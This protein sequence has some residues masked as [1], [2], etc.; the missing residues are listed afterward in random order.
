MG[1]SALLAS[2][3]V[4]SL[5]HMGTTNWASN[6]LTVDGGFDD[7][8]LSIR[9]KGLKDPLCYNLIGEPGQKWRLFTDGAFKFVVDS[10][11]IHAPFKNPDGTANHTY[12]G[13]FEFAAYDGGLNPIVKLNVTTEEVKVMRGDGTVTSIVWPKKVH[14]SLLL[15]LPEAKVVVK[16][17]QWNV[18]SVS[19]G[20]ATFFVNRCNRKYRLNA[21][22]PLEKMD[23]LNIY[24]NHDGK[25]RYG[26]VM[27]ELSGQEAHYVDDS[28]KTVAIGSKQF[29]VV[30]HSLYD[31]V[32]KERFNCSLVENTQDLLQHP[33]SQYRL[34]L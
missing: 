24:I 28:H 13:S 6:W 17:M 25:A 8:H 26:G 33:L 16:H 4:L 20:N 1:P 19:H 34:N 29:N 14:N 22:A 18:L 31:H 15:E 7:P 32:K 10:S 2:V 12:F 27:G 9:M 30:P 11:L 21:K 3:T 23:F 5:V